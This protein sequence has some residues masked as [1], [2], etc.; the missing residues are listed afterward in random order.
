MK[1]T[2]TFLLAANLLVLFAFSLL[3][4]TEKRAG[5]TEEYCTVSIDYKKRNGIEMYIGLISYEDIR[6]LSDRRLETL[7]DKGVQRPFRSR[8]EILHYLNE[9]GW[10]L[11]GV[12]EDD[13]HSTYYMK[14]RL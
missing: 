1:R 14:R 8:I 9:Q 13:L 12:S 7:E 10:E 4:Y 11:L 6:P 3:A 5:R 2:L